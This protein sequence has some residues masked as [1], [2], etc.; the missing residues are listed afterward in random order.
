MEL[1]D[2]IA[3]RSTAKSLTGTGRRLHRSPACW[4]RPRVRRTMGASS[5]GASSRSM[6]PQREAFADAVAEVTARPDP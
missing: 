5:P 6:A 1:F 4:R 3:P 2:A